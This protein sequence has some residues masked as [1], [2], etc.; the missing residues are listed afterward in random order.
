[1]F[2]LNSPWPRGLTRR[3]WPWAVLALVLVIAGAY[4]LDSSVAV[5]ARN[6]P[7]GLRDFMEQV[8]RYGETDWIIIPTAIFC[9]IFAGLAVI[10]RTRLQ[11]LA[12]LQMLHTFGFILVGVGLPSL[13]ATII[14]RLIGRARP[15]L[16]D[17]LGN[18]SFRPGLA[19]WTQQSF[20]SGH[21]TTALA[22]AFVVGF[23]SK[24]WF[25]AMLLFGIVIALSRIVVGAHYPT[26]VIAGAALGIFG[27]YATRAVF[28]ARGWGFEYRTDGSIRA[29][30][31]TAVRRF[32][33][34]SKKAQRPAR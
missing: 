29:R 20:P 5:W 7:Q 18:F 27:A 19:D 23:L 14:K 22:L 8:T 6:W 3:T 10:M 21:A 1:M 2:D 13:V 26:D 24:R 31:L 16:L 28:A 11:K 30:D 9:V 32:V 15:E 4:F 33:R 17:T 25:A 12:M 34:S